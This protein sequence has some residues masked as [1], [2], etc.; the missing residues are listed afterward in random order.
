MGPHISDLQSWYFNVLRE[1][2]TTIVRGIGDVVL[3][4]IT[5]CI[6]YALDVALI[7]SENYFLQS[8]ELS[9]V[10]LNGSQNSVP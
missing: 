5:I 3:L 9:P 4:H 7:G 8:M 6:I 10:L 1:E 2:L